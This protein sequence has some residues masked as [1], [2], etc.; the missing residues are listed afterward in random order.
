MGCLNE[1]VRRKRYFMKI[2]QEQ[3]K[4][5]DPLITLIMEQLGIIK[6]EV[7]LL[8]LVVVEEVAGVVGVVQME[9]VAMVMEAAGVEDVAEMVEAAGVEEVAE[10]VAVE[11]DD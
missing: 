5:L 11:I 2:I 7:G 3:D 10:V 9:E 1:P 6:L 4:F 8:E